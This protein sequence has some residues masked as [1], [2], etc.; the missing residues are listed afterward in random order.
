[1]KKRVQT[2]GL[3]LL[4]AVLG[5]LGLGL[6]K[7]KARLNARGEARLQ[8]EVFTKATLA[9]LG[10]GARME[11]ARSRAAFGASA[12]ELVVPV[13]E[14]RELANFSYPNLDEN[15]MPTGG[16]TTM[17]VTLAVFVTEQHE[18]RWDLLYRPAGGLVWRKPPI[19]AENARLGMAA[20][21]LA[22]GS[23]EFLPLARVKN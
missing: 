13:I 15:D 19:V 23:Y 21:V 14:G 8:A 10:A 7:G 20:V 5:L 3:V 11:G 4:V 6:G 2:F 18:A 1:M 16:Y 22:Q 9:R 12:V 17:D